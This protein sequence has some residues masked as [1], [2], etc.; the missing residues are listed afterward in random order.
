M[1]A[2][3]RRARAIVPYGTRIIP[4]TEA[5]VNNVNMARASAGEQ[6]PIKK[7]IKYYKIVK[8]AIDI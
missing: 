6:L 1:R 4:E 8:I 7:R 5:R 3:R 2:A